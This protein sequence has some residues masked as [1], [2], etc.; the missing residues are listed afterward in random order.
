MMS[1]FTIFWSLLE[2]G[3]QLACWAGEIFCKLAAGSFHMGV[4]LL[5]ALFKLAIS[6]FSWVLDHILDLSVWSRCDLS[7][8]LWWSLSALL[9]ACV[10]I[11]LAAC[12]SSL[13]RRLRH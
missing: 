2:S 11:G 12:A 7:G 10:V 8:I 3:W 1:I 13:C 4:K 9:A 6:P 5:S